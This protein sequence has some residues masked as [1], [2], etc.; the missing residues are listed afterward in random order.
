[1]NNKFVNYTKSLI[2]DFKKIELVRLED[3]C[4]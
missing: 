2:L 3:G 4:F 1:M